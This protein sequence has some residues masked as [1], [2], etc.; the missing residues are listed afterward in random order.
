VLNTC[1]AVSFV[2]K[3][4][5]APTH[6]ADKDIQGVRRFL[7]EQ[8]QIDP[9][10]YL[11]EGERVY[12]KRGPLQGIE[13]YIVKKQSHCRLVISFQSMLKSISITVDEALVEKI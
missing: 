12:I 13:G 8:T 4:N 10:P 7:Q 6:V 9:F 5:Y 2:G 1:G 3:S 11:A